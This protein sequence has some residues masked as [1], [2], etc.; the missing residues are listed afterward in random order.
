MP[1]GSCVKARPRG[2][3][4][5]DSYRGLTASEGVRAWQTDLGAGGA[6]S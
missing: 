6:R 4:P 1:E 3:H 5:Q 2:A